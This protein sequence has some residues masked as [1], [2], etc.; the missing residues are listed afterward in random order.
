M[1]CFPVTIGSGTGE[2]DIYGNGNNLRFSENSGVS[3]AKVVVDTD[4]QVDGDLIV[5]GN[6]TSVNVEDLNVEQGEITLN[7]AA[8]SDTSSSANGA[9]IRIQ[10][11]VDAS[12]DATM[13]WDTTNDRF[14]FS[15]GVRAPFFT[16]DGGRGFKQDRS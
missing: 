5:T 10:D 1:L 4:L 7:Y 15:H 16:S 14:E 12:N 6:T 3:G 13:L 9:G 2:W 11:A 8:S